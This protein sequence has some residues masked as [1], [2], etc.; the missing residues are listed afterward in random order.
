MTSAPNLP[1]QSSGSEV[2]P[3]RIREVVLKRLGIPALL[4]AALALVALASLSSRHAWGAAIAPRVVAAARAAGQEALLSREIERY[5]LSRAWGVDRIFPKFAL[6]LAKYPRGGVAHRTLLV[7][8][9]D[10]NG[11]FFGGP[12]HPAAISTPGYFNKLFFSD[13]PKDGII[14]LRE[15]YRIQS[16]GRLIVSGRV[17]S[18]WLAMP[19]SYEYYVNGQSGLDFGSYPR[20]AQKLT[21]D[22]MEAAYVSF[23][24]NLSYFDNDGPDGV[25]SSGDDDGYIDATIVIHPGHGAEVA[26]SG[27]ELNFLWSH[28]AG[29]TVY[30]D[31]PQPSSPNCLPGMQLGNARGFL[32]TM[33]SEYNW[34]PG[35]KT[36]GTYMHEFGHTLGLADLYE[37]SLCGRPIG[38]GVGL[39]SLMGLGNYLPLLPQELEG[40]RAGSIDAWS[41]QF[42]GFEQPTVATGSGHHTLPPL[43]RGGGVLKVWKNGQPGS[44]YFLVENRV[45]EGPDEFLPGAGLVIYH[46]DDTLIDNCRDCDLSSCAAPP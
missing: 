42:L 5:Q 37:W 17:T 35:D 36:N 13:D 14:S 7:V 10:F 43:E 21:E 40:T 32:Y 31:C 39:Y 4:A 26:Q 28:E 34:A 24:H 45:N 27:T 2:E 15:Y 16:H 25:P 46:V 22:A 19:H 11:D 8:L 18:E 41:R 44:E 38:T 9:C 1:P 33:N 3:T 20:S 30:Q 23:G 6:D 12:V 29:I